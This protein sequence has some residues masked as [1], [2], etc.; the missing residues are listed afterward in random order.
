MEWEWG[1]RVSWSRGGMSS[2]TMTSSASVTLPCCLSISI[3]VPSDQIKARSLAS[4]SGRCHHDGPFGV[5]AFPRPRPWVSRF[6]PLPRPPPP[7][8]LPRHHPFPHIPPLVLPPNLAIN[9]PRCL[10]R[11]QEH[12]IAQPGARRNPRLPSANVRHSHRYDRYTTHT[13]ECIYKVE[14]QVTV[15]LSSLSCLPFPFTSTTACSN[16]F[17]HAFHLTRPTRRPFGYG[18]HRHRARPPLEQRERQRRR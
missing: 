2:L 18:D 3:L 11:P 17:D 10:R 1:L 4:A 13:T 5:Q 12:E 9:P 16:H 6:T 15:V 8:P 7:V 14:R